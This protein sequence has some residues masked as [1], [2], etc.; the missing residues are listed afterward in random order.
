VI[1]LEILD[2]D[3]EH[4]LRQRLDL[5]AEIGLALGAALFLGRDLVG[6]RISLMT[7]PAPF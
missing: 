6:R 4:F 7:A 5:A 3:A 1:P 2:R